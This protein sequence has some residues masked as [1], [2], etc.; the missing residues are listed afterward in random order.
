MRK[1]F[2]CILI[3]GFCSVFWGI[4]DISITKPG[5]KF[6]QIT[7]ED[8]L[9]QNTIHSIYQDDKGFMWF[10]TQGGLNRYNGYDFKAYTHKP[11]DTNSLSNN[12]IY[13]ICG[14]E[15]GYLWLGTGNGLDRF[16]PARETFKRFRHR[17][18]VPSSLS[19]NHVLALY[20]D[21][22]GVLWIGTYGG[23][24]NRLDPGSNLFRHYKYVDGDANS[25]SHNDISAI[26]KDALGN[27]WVGTLGGGL[28][29]FNHDDETFNRFPSVGHA[30][31]KEGEGHINCLAFD[32]IGYLWIGTWDY[33][34]KRFDPKTGKYR[35]Y[36]KVP[37][38]KN[39]LSSNL[40]F[41][42]LPSKNGAL[43]VG[44]A[45]GLDYFDPSRNTFTEYLGNPDN[46]DSL[47]G[48][49]ILSL[50]R[51]S[52]GDTWIGT[53][54]NGINRMNCGQKNFFLYRHEVGNKNSLNNNNV[55]GFYQDEQKKDILWIGTRGGGLNRYNRS[56]GD[57]KFYQHD[58]QNPDSIGHN[59]VHVIRGRRSGAFWLGTFGG[60]A[61]RFIEKQNRFIQYRKN[62]Q[63]AGSIG[64]DYISVIFEDSKETMWIGTMDGGLNRYEDKQDNFTVW[65]AIEGNIAG[66]SSNFIRTIHEDKNG[67]FWIG[68]EGGGLNRFDCGSGEFRH[69]RHN[70]DNPNSL[71]Y[72]VILSFFQA[73]DDTFWIGTAG[74]GLNR[75][76]P[77][78]GEFR[79]YTDLDGLPDNT[80][81]A[82]L[83]DYKGHLWLSTNGGISRFNP[84]SKTFTNYD[85]SDGLQSNEFNFGAA[86][87]TGYG[88]MFFG[89]VNGFNSFF[90][91]QITLNPIKPEILITEFKLFNK[92]VPIGK[93]KDGRVILAKSLMDTKNIILSQKDSV[94]S[95]EYI[96]LNYK[97]AHKNQYAYMMEGFDHDWIEAGTRRFASYTNLP[98]GSYTFK[99]K[100]SNNDGVWNEQ[101]A[102]I[103]I[104]IRPPFWVNWWFGLLVILTLSGLILFLHQLS[105]RKERGITKR[106]EK[107]VARRI[108]EADQARVAAEA[109][110]KSK[111]QF[112]ARMSHEIRTPLNGVTGFISLLMDT[113]LNPEQADYVKSINI[114]GKALLALVND[115]LDFSKIEAGHMLL[116]QVDFSIQT[117]VS[118]VAKIFGS[119][120]ENKP[121]TVICSIAEG[122]A[123]SVIGDPSRFRQ[124]L[125]NLMGN[126][127]KFTLQG[128]I[129]LHLEVDDRNG[130]RIRV[131]TTITDTGIG[132][133]PEKLETIF[134]VFQQADHSTTRQYGGSGLGLSICRQVA[135]LMGGNV[136][137]ESIVEKGSTFHFTA[138]MTVVEHI[139]RDNA[140]INEKKPLAISPSSNLSKIDNSNANI[141]LVE[142]NPL[143]QKLAKHLLKR[144]GYNVELAVNGKEAF[145]KYSHQPDYFALILM[146]LQM[147]VLDGIKAT[148]MI[149]EKEKQLEHLFIPIIAMTAQV[150]KGDRE[151][152]IEAGMND[153][154]SKPI[155]REAMYNTVQKWLKPN[156]RINN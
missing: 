125:I 14:D 132:I 145:D 31:D 84:Y 122:L 6:C 28:N 38:Q 134:D 20:R 148:I 11:G 71:S 27:I 64:G 118:D 92:S 1:G 77:Y 55:Y 99:V 18:D 61:Y 17:Q 102:A 144:A 86:F 22:Y 96:A 41:D 140:L 32:K 69:Y 16:D 81:Y 40:V 94:I 121:V 123:D 151:R 109:A 26:T 110:N 87:K 119:K 85:V 43:W 36:R 53:A 147:P 91:D 57:F 152:C 133:A 30:G 37:G 45:N 142:D 117:I 50:F 73:N 139:S 138:W 49:R 143:N 68:T 137:V 97:F 129:R 149:R 146:D 48:N 154:I 120:I 115:V 9:S 15:D 42:I 79:V 93:N 4:E 19:H 150:L 136:W 35:H 29:R 116:E 153:F 78:F 114:S 54:V 127:A 63:S 90:P 106:L 107:E 23:G 12:F 58:S 108:R 51:D 21:S 95:F 60:G 130:S 111:S 47:T 62:M 105:L 82:I 5:I 131:H 44:T 124:V 66:L 83:S 72:D 135:Q 65:R 75:F 39:C 7:I 76:D 25:I 88:E 56:T 59:E 34:L 98:S 100:G 89:G 156:A 80:I 74:S 24:L 141:L 13:A 112:L 10:G 2:L 52:G 3:F 155:K 33:G 8:G 46:P 103:N 104:T 67:I 70:P 128:E 126:A 101:G 113:P